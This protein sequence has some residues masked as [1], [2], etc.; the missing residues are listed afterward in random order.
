MKKTANKAFIR[1]TALAAAAFFALAGCGG[2]GSHRS[3]S[4][5]A[6]PSYEMKAESTGA[7]YDMDALYEA[8][9]P[10]AYG[11]ESYNDAGDQSVQAE[12]PQDTSRKLITTIHMDAETDDMDAI[13]AHVEARVL[14]LGGYIE[15]S[16]ISNG[17]YRTYSDRTSRVRNASLTLRIPAK[18]LSSFIE[19][20]QENTNITSQSRNVED[21][22]LSY[23]DIDSHKRMLKA[24]ET[25][26]L[27]FLENAETIEDML[28]VEQRL[29]D[30]QYQIDSMESQLRTYDNKINY[31]TVYLTIQEVVEF[32]IPEEEPQTVWEEIA[33]G[34]AEN[35]D[36]VLTGLKNFFVWIVI[37]IPQ[38]IVWA[39]VITIIVIVVRAIRKKVDKNAPLG[40]DGKPMSARERRKQEKQA[41][42]AAKAAG[43]GV[44]PVPPVPPVPPAAGGEKA[45]NYIAR[46][47]G[48]DASDPGHGGS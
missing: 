36:S 1:L 48:G 46:L 47:S 2:S 26:L 38:L 27:K 16:D 9:A 41:K 6:S 37:H 10:E 24:E 18:N 22:T 39:V 20:V 25:R 43:R 33:F 40:P 31:S 29:T 19:D 21:V 32:T 11:E 17:S 42:K 4:D 34:F 45:D 8:E 14:T 7:T 15:S 28:A 30:V 23:A 35:L 3:A 12:T 13:L 44:A 5:A